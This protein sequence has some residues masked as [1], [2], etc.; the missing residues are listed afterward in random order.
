L[1]HDSD[2][3][4]VSAGTGGPLSWWENVASG[5]EETGRSLKPATRIV[6]VTSPTAP[7]LAGEALYDATGRRVTDVKP[8]PGV[9]CNAGGRAGRLV[10]TR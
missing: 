3:D 6:T 1:D 9:Y 8:A 2:L 7:L 4:V 5:I 10:V